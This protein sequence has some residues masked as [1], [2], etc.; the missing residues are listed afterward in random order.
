MHIESKAMRSIDDWDDEFPAAEEGGFPTRLV[1][2]VFISQIQQDALAAQ[3]STIASL[4]ENAQSQKQTHDVTINNLYAQAAVIERLT[5]A[6]DNIQ[7]ELE[8]DIS[9]SAFALI[10][11]RE[12]LAKGLGK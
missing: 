7:C 4:M 11:A 5:N 12:A 6:L 2:E 1:R 3:A 10:L 9:N 8:Y